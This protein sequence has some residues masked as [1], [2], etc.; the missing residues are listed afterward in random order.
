MYNYSFVSEPSDCFRYV[1]KQTYHGGELDLETQQ[2]LALSN[3]CE[4]NG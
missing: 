3:N 4:K 1:T 2:Q